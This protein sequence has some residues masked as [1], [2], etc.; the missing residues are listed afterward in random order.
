MENRRFGVIGNQGIT[1][2]CLQ[3][4][5]KVEGVEVVFVI[6]DPARQNPG[7]GIKE[8]CDKQN[9]PYFA[10]H[11][12]NTPECHALVRQFSPDLILSISNYWVMRKELL[13]IPKNGVIN[14]HNGTPFSYRGINIPSWVV[15]NGEKRHG[16]MWHFADEGV[17]TGDVVGHVLF[18]VDENETAATLM[19][20]CINEG[21]LLFKKIFPD[22]VANTLTRTSQVTHAS[23]YSLKDL[24]E[25]NGV[26]DLSWTYEKLS[27]MVRGLNYLPFPNPLCYA[28]LQYN[29]S[30]VVVNEI[31]RCS[32][33]LPLD[34]APGKIVAVSDDS[35]VVACNDA[36]VGIKN[37][38]G[39][40]HRQ[41][42]S[43]QLAAF[44]GVSSGDSLSCDARTRRSCCG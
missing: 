6:F 7:F 43:S 44:L 26:L 40:A 41:M 33:V 28:R 20:K 30:Q 10:L 35:F 24:P 1:L 15:I 34:A 21:L 5:L 18:D 29:D 22:L 16:V 42:S 36:L 19:V 3:H 17:D 11:A 23:Y 8:F 38:M 13:S 9:I 27:R 12:I 32:D 39:K 14:F 37:T 31:V 25:N 4:M 2:K